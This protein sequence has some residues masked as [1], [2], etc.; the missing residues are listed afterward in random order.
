MGHN[1]HVTTLYVAAGG[2]GDAVGVLLARRVLDDGSRHSALISTCAWER[3]RIDPVPGPRPRRG[4]VGLGQVGGEATELLPT[5]DTTPPGRS[6]L[7]RLASE[8]QLRLFLHD[9]QLGAVGLRDQLRRLADALGAEQLV[10]VDVGGD[11][12]AR[13]AEPNLMSPLADSLTLAAAVAV[14]PPTTVAVI[15]PGV[16]AELSETEVANCLAEVDAGLAGRIEADDVNA[17]G[18]VLAWHPTEATT[19]VAA[20][21]LGVRG[22]AAMRRGGS[23]TPITDRSCEVWTVP[24]PDLANFPLARALS[25]TVTLDEAE[26]LMRHAAINE[27]DYER[28]KATTP[29]QFRTSQPLGVIAR[30]AVASGAT[31]ITSRRL[32][33]LTDSAD[34]LAANQGRL[35]L[36]PLEELVS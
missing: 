28:R 21:A 12:V 11:V 16:D 33:E 26:E 14:G 1:R 15:G 20:S 17:L 2:G 24:N 3:L 36:W 4:F 13:G 19:L 25:D 18:D 8:P 34:M 31:H 35:G 27:L 30:D 7:P 9:L 32:A 22:A 5:S 6:V 29:H 23:P 10:I